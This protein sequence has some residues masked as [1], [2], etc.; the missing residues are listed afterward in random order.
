MPEVS[1]IA[2]VYNTEAY[3]SK[4][5]ESLLAQTYTDFELILVNDGSTDK[6]PEICHRYAAEDERITVIDQ[7]NGGLS[8]A[9]NSGLGIAKGAY[10]QFIDSDDYVE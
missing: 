8:A 4:C 9:R 3:L 5:I 10:I 7:V 1:V 6:S 2:A